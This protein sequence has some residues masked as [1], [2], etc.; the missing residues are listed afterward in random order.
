MVP[1]CR[2]RNPL[3]AAVALANCGPLTEHVR[4]PAFFDH[5]PV[6]VVAVHGDVLAA[7]AGGDAG[8]EPPASLM[9]ARKASNGIT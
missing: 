6:G 5:R 3:T 9:S 7:A 2:S 4:L 8:I 1:G